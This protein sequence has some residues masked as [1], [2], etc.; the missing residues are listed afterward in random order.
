MIEFI[1]QHRD[2][3]GVE[4]ICAELPIA[5]A[6]YYAAKGREP[7]ARALSDAVMA[8]KIRTVHASNHR[9]YGVRKV[10]A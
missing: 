3:F 1:D 5:P 7:S 10:H 8:S 6:T 9:V 2:T 4:P